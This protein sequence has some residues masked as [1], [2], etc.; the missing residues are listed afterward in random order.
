MKPVRHGRLITLEGGEGA[1]KSTQA[2][3][4]RDWLQAR[5]RLAVLTREPGGTPLAEAIR[6]TLLGGDAMPALCE[7][8]LMFAAR[9]SHVQTLIE[10]ALSAGN[11]VICDR[12]VDASYAYQGGGRGIPDADIA[13]LEALTLGQRRPDLVLVFDIAP[14]IGLARTAKRGEQ[15]RFESETLA[16]QQRVRATYLR[17]AHAEP[18]RYAVLDA[19]VSRESVQQQL[20]AILEA[21]L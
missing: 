4:I 18:S 10:P 2:V 7:L 8:L 3:F 9:A 6:Q 21:R 5:G 11:D 1:G 14:E 19:S 17:R 16:F 13:R 20:T 12:F 15:N